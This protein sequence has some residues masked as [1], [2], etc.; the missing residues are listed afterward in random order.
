MPF[1]LGSVE[2]R[3]FVYLFMTRNTQSEKVFYIIVSKRT[4]NTKIM[5]L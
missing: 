1:D 5:N 4:A 3:Y 2:T